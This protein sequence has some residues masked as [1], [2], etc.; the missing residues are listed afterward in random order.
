[1]RPRIAGH[2]QTPPVLATNIS[3]IQSDIPKSRIYLEV[4]PLFARGLVRLPD[5]GRLLN[6]L[7]LLERQTHRGGKDSVDHPRGGH[8]D[9]ANAVCGVLRTL[10]NYLGFSLEAMLADGEDDEKAN[11]ESWQRFRLHQHLRRCGVLI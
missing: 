2:W 5:H 8:D 7:R 9:H 10:S 11:A 1:L 6:E 4:L 3:Y